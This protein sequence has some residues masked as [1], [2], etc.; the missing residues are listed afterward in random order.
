MVSREAFPVTPRTGGRGV[1]RDMSIEVSIKE[2]KEGEAVL[3][4]EYSTGVSASRSGAV[5]KVSPWTGLPEKII[6]SEGEEVEGR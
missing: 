4:P 3:H 1:Q 6:D 5:Y 2:N